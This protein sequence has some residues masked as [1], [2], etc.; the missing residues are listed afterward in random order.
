MPDDI[1]E[2]EDRLG[3]RENVEGDAVRA[4]ASDQPGQ[5]A[6]AGD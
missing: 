5:L 4:I 3:W 1:A 6:A 2:H